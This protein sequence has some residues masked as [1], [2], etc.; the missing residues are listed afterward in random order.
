MFDKK[1]VQM[2]AN[3]SSQDAK[4]SSAGLPR[5]SKSSAFDNR[6]TKRVNQDDSPKEGPSSW[7]RKRPD[8]SSLDSGPEQFVVT[9][10]GCLDA[11][12]AHLERVDAAGSVGKEGCPTALVPRRFVAVE[13]LPVR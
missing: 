9:L 4:S 7:L 13:V 1:S 5:S 6:M 8:C 11:A 3:V 10:D 2:Q 12:P